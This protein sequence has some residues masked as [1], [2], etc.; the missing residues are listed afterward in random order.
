MGFTLQLRFTGLCAFVAHP[1]G[2]RMR[3]VLVDASKPEPGAHE[4]GPMAHEPHLPVL[5]YNQGDLAEPRPAD[6]TFK[7]AGTVNYICTIHPNQTGKVV[8]K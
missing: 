2:K 6:E 4:H 1:K 3:V 5:V 8:V 7:D